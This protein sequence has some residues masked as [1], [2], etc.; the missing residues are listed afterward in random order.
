KN[1]ETLIAVVVYTNALPFASAC[2]RT[3]PLAKDRGNSALFASAA[4][5]A[6]KLR[7]RPAEG[8]GRG[9]CWASALPLRCQHAEGPEERLGVL[10]VDEVLGG[11]ARQDVGPPAGED[12]PGPNRDLPFPGHPHVAAGVTVRQGVVGFAE[13]L[14]TGLLEQ[15]VPE[16]VELLLVGCR[17]R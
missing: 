14:A 1:T 11:G 17:L 12:E 5:D 9:N 2:E 3:Y 15:L 8:S 6:R 4:V 10:A 16:P 7:G 13:Q